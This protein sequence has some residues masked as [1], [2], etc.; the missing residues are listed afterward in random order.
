[1]KQSEKYVGKEM[2]HPDLG[3][4]KVLS[5]VKHSRVKVNVQVIDK[6]RGFNEVKDRYTGVR[7]KTGWYRGEN[8]E[9]GHEDEVHIKDLTE[10]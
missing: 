2:L 7:I 8:R 3:K 5:I 9:Y 4:V 10:C 1:M 6:G